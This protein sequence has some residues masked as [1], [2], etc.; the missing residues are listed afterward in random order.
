M[1]PC[2]CPLHMAKFLV[3]WLLQGYLWD[4]FF[5]AWQLRTPSISVLVRR[6]KLCPTV[7]LPCTLS[8]KA[9]QVCPEARGLCLP[10]DE[11]TTMS[12]SRRAHWVGEM[13]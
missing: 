3:L 1:E 4:F 11:E 2:T 13:L 12:H 6:Q 10:R 8:L 9:T 5:F 7:G